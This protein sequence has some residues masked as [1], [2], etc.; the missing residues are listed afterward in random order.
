MGS[1]MDVL[2][3]LNNVNVA[4]VAQAAAADNDDDD[5]DDATTTTTT[6]P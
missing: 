3:A 2:K 6:D 4:S 1:N 5:D